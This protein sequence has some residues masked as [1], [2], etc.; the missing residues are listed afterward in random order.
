MIN[1]IIL[2]IV[3]LV[4]IVVFKV[5]YSITKQLRYK[6]ML[7]YLSGNGDDVIIDNNTL[8]CFDTIFW[9]SILVNKYRPIHSTDYD[10]FGF[11]GRPELF[12]LVGGFGYSFTIEDATI[13]I[14]AND[15]YDW[16]PAVN[17]CGESFW[18]ASPIVKLPRWLR[19]TINTVLGFD[20]IIDTFT[21]GDGISNELWYRLNGTEFTSKMTWTINL[22]LLDIELNNGIIYNNEYDGQVNIDYLQGDPVEDFYIYYSYYYNIYNMDEHYVIFDELEEELIQKTNIKAKRGTRK[23][24][25]RARQGRNDKNSKYI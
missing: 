9:S 1:N 20:V 15:V 6:F 21:G 16:H 4:T 2:L 22:S 8:S 11:Y 19:N 10:E 5:M 3:K 24:R 17:S 18:F 12:F 25:T 23:K 13:T 14:T 7:H